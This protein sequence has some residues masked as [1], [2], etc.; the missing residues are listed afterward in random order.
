MDLENPEVVDLQ[1]DSTMYWIQKFDLD[2]FRHDATKHIPLDFLRKLTRRLKEDRVS[3]GKKV[4]QIGETYGSRD[5]VN[6]YIGSGL[7]DAQFDFNLY[8]QSKYTS[9]WVFQTQSF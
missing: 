1:V 2:G 7:L 5:L 6:S 8:Y 9:I 4:Y 3:K